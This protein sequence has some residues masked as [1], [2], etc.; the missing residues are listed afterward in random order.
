MWEEIIHS[1]AETPRDIQTRPLTR[2][3]PLWFYVYVENDSLFVDCARKHEPSSKISIPR[4][5]ASDADKCAVMYNLYLRRKAG[6]QVSE[7]ATSITANQ[8]YW[9]GVFAEMEY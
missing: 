3:I 7:E 5:L 9:Y 1:F 6:E 8:V 4:K 2:K